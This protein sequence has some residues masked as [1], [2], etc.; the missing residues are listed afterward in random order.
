MFA[1]FN[2]QDEQ[3][4]YPQWLFLWLFANYYRQYEAIPLCWAI[5]VM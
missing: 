2:C 4:T 1:L 3:I 5:A